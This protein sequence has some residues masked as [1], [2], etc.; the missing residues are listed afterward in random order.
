MS[1]DPKHYNMVFEE[2]KRLFGQQ[3]YDS[4][5][6]PTWGVV[7]RS[8]IKHRFF[9]QD[10]LIREMVAA[11][12]EAC[13]KGKWPQGKSFFER[14]ENVCLKNRREARPTI[15]PD[16]GMQPAADILKNRMANLKPNGQN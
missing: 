15:I 8:Q 14:L 13:E 4:V 2:M 6:W 5:D 9:E 16:R 10:I 3:W 11:M 1:F 7:W 12:P